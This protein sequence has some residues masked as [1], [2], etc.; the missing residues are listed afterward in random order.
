M[1]FFKQVTNRVPQQYAMSLARLELQHDQLSPQP[2]R[3]TW[4][5]FDNQTTITIHQQHAYRES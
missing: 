4:T 5:Y 2:N 1:A 3:R